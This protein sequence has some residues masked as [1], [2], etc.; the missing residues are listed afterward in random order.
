MYCISGFV[1]EAKCIPN[2]YIVCI[3]FV[4][5]LYCIL[6]ELFVCLLH[7]KQ[8][9]IVLVGYISVIA[10]MKIPLV[11]GEIKIR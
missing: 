8:D 5:D 11:T 10:N 7:L 4:F 6:N 3:E 2:T 9:K 1:F